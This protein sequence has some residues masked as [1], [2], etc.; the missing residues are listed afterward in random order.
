M[1]RFISTFFY[2]GLFPI[3]PGTMGS[4]LALIL[5]LPAAFVPQNLHIIFSFFVL[6]ILFGFYSIPKYLHGRTDDLQEIV[7]D[8]AAGLY[9]TIL[10]AMVIMRV[11]GVKP[12][13]FALFG[14]AFVMFRV[15]D[16]TKP[17]IIG[18]YDRT[19]KG[20]TGIMVDDILAGLFAGIT[21]AIFLIA[22][23]TFK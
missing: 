18:Y 5:I 13:A 19:L 12:N 21:T 14:V 22:F 10:L 23:H 3:A 16:I 11:C 7:I 6:S 8:E 9:T 15:F 17:L 2:S 1:N 4:V 20:A